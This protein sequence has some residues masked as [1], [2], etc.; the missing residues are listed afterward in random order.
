MVRSSKLKKLNGKTRHKRLTKKNKRGGGEVEEEEKKMNAFV[1][2]Y[3]DNRKNNI[4]FDQI[5]DGAGYIKLEY[6]NDLLTIFDFDFN[7]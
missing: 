4:N 2:T 3:N 1:L 7:T 6:F 5:D